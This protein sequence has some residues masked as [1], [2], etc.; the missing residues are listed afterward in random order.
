MDRVGQGSSKLAKKTV[1]D[2]VHVLNMMV[3]YLDKQQSKKR[4]LSAKCKVAD[5]ELENQ[6]TSRKKVKVGKENH[7]SLV[8][9]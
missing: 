4:I 6:G 2:M 5:L 3:T 7:V 9:S 1:A 8:L